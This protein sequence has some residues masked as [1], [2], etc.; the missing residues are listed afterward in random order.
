MTMPGS[1]F[2][3]PPSTEPEGEPF[4]VRFAPGI[5]SPPRTH[6]GQSIEDN[7]VGPSRIRHQAPSSP[8]H[9]TKKSCS[10]VPDTPLRPRCIP[11]VKV[12][13]ERFSTDQADSSLLL[14]SAGK[15]P[16]KCTTKGSYTSNV[17]VSEIN[18]LSVLP[19]P[20]KRAKDAPPRQIHPEKF[21]YE[22]KSWS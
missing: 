21:A 20:K 1:L 22:A 19:L 9:A 2:P 7:D 16:G 18:P 4:H 13:V 8:E 12:A 10:S 14:P 3:R 5:L 6:A 11:S 17:N 15:S